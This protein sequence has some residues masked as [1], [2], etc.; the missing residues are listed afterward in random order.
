MDKKKLH[1]ILT[2]RQA[3]KENIKSEFDD[4]IDELLAS[5]LKTKAGKLRGSLGATAKR[6]KRDVIGTADDYRFGYRKGYMGAAMKA[7]AKR[8]AMV[9]GAIDPNTGERVVGDKAWDIVQRRMADRRLGKGAPTFSDQ[10]K[11]NAPTAAKR[12]EFAREYELRQGKPLP[13]FTSRYG[14]VQRTEVDPDT[15]KVTKKTEFGFQPGKQQTGTSGKYMN[16][17]TSQR[18]QRRER[19]QAQAKRLAGDPEA[20]KAFRDIARARAMAR[21]EEEP[22]YRKT[23]G[24]RTDPSY[25]YTTEP[26]ISRT[27]RP[28]S[29]GGV[30]WYK[31]GRG[32]PTD[33][34]VKPET[35]LVPEDPLKVDAT[36]IEHKPSNYNPNQIERGA[37]LPATTRR[38][39]S[40]DV[41]NL[42]D[43]PLEL[44]AGK[45]YTQ[46]PVKRDPTNIALRK[47]HLEKLLQLRKSG[48][49]SGAQQARKTFKQ[50]RRKKWTQKPMPHALSRGEIEHPDT[51]ID[52][53]HTEYLGTGSPL[54]EMLRRRLRNA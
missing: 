14:D 41:K 37:D 30:P 49:L 53:A 39:W 20:V 40:W 42:K 50:T 5:T 31:V 18:I 29:K 27:G 6:I 44:P 11:M 16:Q 33:P 38:P 36:P 19:Q 24:D 52:R 25:P 51:N 35:S 12:D 45:R 1:D 21:G 4:R 7:Q 3:L 15:G 10:W 28:I 32:K 54:R 17:T 8:D 23:S 9:G 22:E 48:N 26:G 13:G 2:E 34:K 47:K 46:D 43:A